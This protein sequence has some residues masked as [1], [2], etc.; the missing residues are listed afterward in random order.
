MAH[1]STTSFGSWQQQRHANNGKII[2]N[3]IFGGHAGGR[4]NSFQSDSMTQLHHSVVR[5]HSHCNDNVVA[6]PD[7]SAAG[8]ARQ[9]HAVE[10]SG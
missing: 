2:E 8:L 9:S 6:V 10:E 4:G 1:E 3:L 5:L 7:R